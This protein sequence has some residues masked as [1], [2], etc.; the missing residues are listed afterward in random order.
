MKS[1]SVIE[2]RISAALLMHYC[3]VT[4]YSPV[5]NLQYFNLP[6]IIK[7]HLREAIQ[8]NVRL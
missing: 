8:Q 3:L 2:N 4:S 5:L 7:F 6:L 1:Q